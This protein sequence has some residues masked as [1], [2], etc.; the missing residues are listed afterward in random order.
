[1]TCVAFLQGYWLCVAL[2]VATS[3]PVATGYGIARLA[4][5]Q[6]EARRFASERDA[7]RPFEPLSLADML[8][9]D[10][11]F[12]ATPVEQHAAVVFVDLSGFTGV[13]ESLGPAWTRE[14]LVALHQRIETV[15]REQQGFI[16]SYMG[17]G[18][19]I[20]FGLPAWQPD[21]AG[22]AL[23]AVG[24]LYESLSHWI[25]TLPPAARD[26]LA[27]RVGG[28]FGSVVL[29][30]LGTPDHQHI[31]A[32][33]DTVNVAS[34]LLEVAKE[35]HAATAVSEDLCHAAR[36]VGGAAHD[37]AANP[38]LE[39]TIRGRAKP[40]LVRLRAGPVTR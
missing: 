33:G 31:T 36:D 27:P 29:S 23:R 38:A 37:D 32:T 13:T 6:H 22:R 14:L 18:A 16:V 24:R 35:H 7:L 39:V 34:R 12:L 3:I 1:L 26:R 5:A 4:L 10:P 28:H 30:R 8:V 11:K 9:R 40:I 2:P 19:M 17:D 25:A 20:L 21:D 15:A